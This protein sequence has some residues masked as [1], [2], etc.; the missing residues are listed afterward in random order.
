VGA[1][2]DVHQDVEDSQSCTDAVEDDLSMGA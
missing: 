1:A 2:D